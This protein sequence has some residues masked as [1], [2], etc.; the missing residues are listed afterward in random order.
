MCGIS[1]ICNFKKKPSL[2]T[3]KKMNLELKHRG[4][5][6]EG[7]FTNNYVCLGHT[8]LSIID[9]NKSKQP[10]IDE[11]SKNVLIFNGEIYNF[12]ELKNELKQLGHKFITDG[13]TEVILK[14]YKEWGID[15]LKRFEGMFV[16]IIW[17]NKKKELIMARDRIGEKPLFYSYSNENGLIFASEI[18]AF[19]SVQELKAKLQLNEKSL[20][21]YLS[22]NYLISNQTFFK[23]INSLE[24][25]SYLIINKNNIENL[26]SIKYWHLENYFKNKTKDNYQ[27]S[28][29]KISE[30]IEGSTKKRFFSNV[31][32]GIF[33]SGGL[34]SSILSYQLKNTE[35]DNF[36]THNIAFKEADFDEYKDAK[37]ISE[38]FKA[39]LFSYNIPIANQLVNEFPNI[40]DAMDQPMSDTSFIASY[41]LSKFS[42]KKS[43]MVLSGDGADELFCGYD[44]FI[45]DKLRNFFPKITSRLNLI[46]YILNFLFKSKVS[47]I[48]INYK[49]NKFIN[50]ISYDKNYS[51]V[52]WREIFTLFEKKKIINSDLD[53]HMNYDFLN[54]IDEQNKLVSDLNY[55]DRYLYIDLKTWLPND[56]LYKIDRSTMYN[57]QEARVPFLDSKLIEYTSSLPINF[58]LNFFKRKRILKDAMINK[59]PKMSF[60]KK[61]SGF[62]SPIG[63]WLQDNGKFKEMG[64]YLIKT[65][66]MQNIFNIDE[67]D[68]IW[69]SH[70]GN[71]FDESFKIFNLMC[72]SQWLENNSLSGNL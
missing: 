44:T 7:Y 54:Y 55:I 10:M 71:K 40:V 46:T 37:L 22:L 14:S 6:D 4:P 38:F 63:I 45:A 21:Q 20:N 28:I 42:S 9:L 57:S 18:K 60:L 52:L 1:G 72:L 3:V 33:L 23:N 61:K 11:N 8:R 58:K 59:L 48:G 17:D 39:N 2:E 51:H 64:Y 29:K 50:G 31:T 66:K 53:E 69:K 68:K 36:D 12:R 65:K 19:L 30:L 5:D 70:Q 49:I 13:D 43:K 26:R 27:A 62:N 25:A 56:V 67:I 34:D 47:K 35:S 32:N 16:F 41:Y 24:P 15:C